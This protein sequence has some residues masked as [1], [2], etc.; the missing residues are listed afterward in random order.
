[1]QETVKMWVRSL[2]R[3]IPWS[4][5]WQHTPVFLHGKFHGERN[6]AGCSP[7]GHKELDMTMNAPTY[8]YHIHYMIL[9]N[10]YYSEFTVESYYYI[11]MFMSVF[12]SEVSFIIFYNCLFLTLVS[13]NELGSFT[14]LSYSF[15]L[16]FLSFLI[17]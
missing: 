10:C 9:I 7:W 8:H 11:N 2:I 4:R 6:L 1:M 16:F 17:Y 5:K 14:S 12:I 15:T 13:W 3:K